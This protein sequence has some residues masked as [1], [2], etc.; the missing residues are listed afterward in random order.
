ML[1]SVSINCDTTIHPWHRPGTGWLPGRPRQ[2]QWLAPQVVPNLC[3]KMG[4]SKENGL[5]Y[6]NSQFFTLMYIEKLFACSL[7]AQKTWQPQLSVQSQGLKTGNNLIAIFLVQPQ[8]S[9]L[10]LA[11]A[12]STFPAA[13]NC[14]AQKRPKWWLAW[15]VPALFGGTRTVPV[16]WFSHED[17]DSKPNKW[18]VIR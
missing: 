14:P 18:V 5:K 11:L 4:I 7:L 15:A 2:H 9:K 10:S 3:I 13:V 17:W 1:P 12:G 8:T 16:F 6:R